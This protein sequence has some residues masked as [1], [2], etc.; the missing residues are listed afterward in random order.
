LIISPSDVIISSNITEPYAHAD[1]SLSVRFSD[2][3]QMK[4]VD[5]KIRKAL[6]AKYKDIIHLQVEGGLRR[7]AMLYSDKT[8]EIWKETKNIA[9][10]LDIRLNR[11]HRWSSADIC[12]V[13]DDKAVIDGMGPIGSK[14]NNKSE[15][16]LRHSLLE[17]ATLLA[18]TINRLRSLSAPKP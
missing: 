6:P 18:L 4:S 2:A 8:D 15:Y 9:D 14:P 11:E 16:I 10:R 3:E 1:A 12:F 17:R 5:Q 7:P 13:G